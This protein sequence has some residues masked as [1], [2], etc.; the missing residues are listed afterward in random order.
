[1]AVAVAV[2]V[3][4]KVRVQVMLVL[5]LWAG[6][7]AGVPWRRWCPWWPWSASKHVWLSREQVH[8]LPA[9]QLLAHVGQSET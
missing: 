5:V 3:T 6:A 4:V 1:M 2:M 7:V 8:G 9:G